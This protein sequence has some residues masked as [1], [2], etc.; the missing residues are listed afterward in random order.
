MKIKVS[1]RRQVKSL[2]STTYSRNKISNANAEI[3]TVRLSYPF[4]LTNS[5]A[6][7][8]TDKE[9]V[10]KNDLP[11]GIRNITASIRRAI[12]KQLTAKQIEPARVFWP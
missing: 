4:R 9:A 8:I 1:T 10:I 3:G 6:V 5:T 12:K 7:T 11:N 2:H